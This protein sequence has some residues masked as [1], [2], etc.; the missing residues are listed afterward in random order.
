MVRRWR[1]GPVPQGFHQRGHVPTVFGCQL[2]DA[3]DQEFPVRVARTLPFG[4]GLVVVVQPGGFGGGGADHG[5]RHVQALGQRVD[6]V[7]ARR[8]GQVPGRGQVQTVDR[9][10]LPRRAT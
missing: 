4:R 9:G 1:Q 8:P 10:R 2:V 6:R 3:G 7:R 5:D